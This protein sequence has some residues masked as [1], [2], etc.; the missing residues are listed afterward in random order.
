MNFIETYAAVKVSHENNE[1]PVANGV[2]TGEE[3]AEKSRVSVGVVDGDLSSS[4]ELFLVRAVVGN[5]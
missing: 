2:E 1:L 4:G 3:G 5:V